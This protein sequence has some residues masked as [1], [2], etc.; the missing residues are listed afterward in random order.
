MPAPT[1]SRLD[2][3]RNFAEEL[4]VAKGAALRRLAALATHDDP[5]VA[6]RACEA[7]IKLDGQRLRAETRR[8]VEVIRAGARPK[9][10]PR[11]AP[12]AEA[13]APEL[14]KARPTAVRADGTPLRSWLNP[15]G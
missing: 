7:I 13:R 10:D 4:L 3:E 11:P 15:D 9:A 6:L 1:D 5:K 12:P 2:A 14:A 8:E